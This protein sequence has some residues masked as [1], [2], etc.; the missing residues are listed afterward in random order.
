MKYLWT[1]PK[2]L[3]K[4]SKKVLELIKRHLN[5]GKQENLEKKSSLVAL[6]Y[7]KVYEKKKKKKPWMEIDLSTA[8]I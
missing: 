3:Y 1:L 8:K 6:W 4:I 2:R 7:K 5:T